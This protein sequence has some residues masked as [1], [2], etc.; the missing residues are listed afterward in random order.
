MKYRLRLPDWQLRS[1]FR[2]YR[3]SFCSLR[4]TLRSA[5]RTVL[6]LCFKAGPPS[7]VVAY[8]KVDM[9]CWYL[10]FGTKTFRLCLG[11]FQVSRLPFSSLQ[12][13]CRGSAFSWCASALNQAA[14]QRLCTHTFFGAEGYEQQHTV[15]VSDLTWVLESCLYREAAL[16]VASAAVEALQAAPRWFRAPRP[17]ESNGKKAWVALVSFWRDL[18]QKWDWG[19]PP[20]ELGEKG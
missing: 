14:L 2:S 18:P 1:F 7:Q 5:F 15:W 9:G 10:S 19:D 16:R 4:F 3:R 8:S 17:G 6:L 11:T 13:R 20:Q 12:S